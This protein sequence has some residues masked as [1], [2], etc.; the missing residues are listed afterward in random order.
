MDTLASVNPKVTEDLTNRLDDDCDGYA[1]NA[2]KGSKPTDTQDLDGDGYTL[3]MGDCDDRADAANI[4]VAKSRHPGATEICDNGIDEDCD[5]IPDNGPLCDPNG[6]NKPPLTIDP[7]ITPIPIG[8]GAVKNGVFTAG[9]GV[10]NV[11]P[12]ADRRRAMIQLSL[13]GVRL[14]LPLTDA[15]G[16][17]SVT[18]GFLGGVI[19]A[20]TLALTKGLDADKI[21]SAEQTLLDAIFVGQIGTILGLDKDKATATCCRTWTSTA[22]ASRTF[23]QEGLRPPSGIPMV[24]TCKDGNGDRHHEQL[25]RQGHALLARGDPRTARATS[26]FV[27]G[28]SVA[29]KV[30]DAVPATIAK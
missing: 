28:I 26:R 29:L 8:F 21:I 5:G 2:V 23:Y 6:V 9:P 12:A 20:T 27:D 19:S 11:K 3:A 4:D 7:T 30:I 13:I 14:Q 1:D 18:G 15:G 22:T 25:R 16:N 24:D 17:T 10:F